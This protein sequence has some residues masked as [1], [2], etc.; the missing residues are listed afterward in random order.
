MNCFQRYGSRLG[1]RL[2][3]KTRGDGRALHLGT[4]STDEEEGTNSKAVER[5]G[6]D[7]TQ[8]ITPEAAF[9]ETDYGIQKLP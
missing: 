4:S 7:I 8:C 3:P 9:G 1:R 2:S 5:K 6:R